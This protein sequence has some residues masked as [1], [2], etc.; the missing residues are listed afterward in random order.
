MATIVLQYAGAAVGTFLGGPLGGIIGR[1]VG[2]VVGNVVDQNLFGQSTSREG[3]RLNG[4]QVMSSEEGASIPVVFGRMRIG[5]QVIWASSIEE[6]A[7]TTTSSASGKGGPT[8]TTTE[9]SYFGSF[10]V[11]LCEG[12]IAGI[13]RVWADGQDIDIGQ[14]QTRL[15]TGS[16]TQNAD[17]L[18]TSAMTVAPAYR[19]LAYIVFERLPLASFG[20]RIP[21][22][23][24]EVLRA[25]TQL[26]RALQSV[27][28]IPGATEF[29]YDTTII[30]RN[31]GAGQTASE[32]AHVSAS[33]SDWSVSLNQLQAQCP[34]VS[35]ASLVVAWFGDDLRCGQCQ[36]RPGVDSPAKSTSPGT[37]SAGGISRAAAHQ[38]S[39][40]AGAPAFGGT[41]SDSSVVRAIQDMKARGFKVTFYPFILMDVPAGNAL[42]DPYGGAA[43][44]AYPWRGRMTA[45]KAPGV[46]GSPDKTAALTT[47]LASFVGT[48]TASNFATSGTAVTYSGPAEWS[49]RRMILHYAKLCAAAGGVDTFLIGSELVGL[50]TL[51]SSAGAYP[52]VA[53]LQTLAADVK[54]I[55]PSAKISYAADWSEYFGHHPTDGSNDVY[56]HLDPLWASSSI[57]F[58]GVDNYLPLADWRDGTAHL[59]FQAGT[60]TIYDQNYLQANIAGGEFYEWYYASQ[61]ARD[62][63][64]RSPITDGAYGKPWIYRAKDFKSWWLNPHYNRP[65]GVESLTATSWVAQSKPFRFTELGCPAVDKGL[66]QPN[67]FVDAKSSESA[68]PWYSNGTADDQ[69]QASYALAMQNYWGVSGS[70]NPV[71]TIYGGPMVSGADLSFWA[72]DARPYPAFPAKLDVWADG[73]N[74]QRGHWLNGRMASVEL[75]TLITE[76]ASRFG[77]E[78]VDVSGVD[79]RVDGFVIDRPMSARDALEGL[80]QAFAIDAVE[81]GGQLKFTAR[82]AVEVINVTPADL[83]ETAADQPILVTTRAQETDIPAA[84]K[85]TYAEAAVD[86]RSAAVSAR[87]PQTSSVREVTINLPAAI[88]QAEAQSRADMAL[89]ESW[90]ARESVKFALPPS[91]AEVEPG[92]VIALQGNL[93]RVKSL[94]EGTARKIEAQAFDSTLYAVVLTT[95]RDVTAPDPAVFGQSEVLLMDLAMVQA[96]QSPAPW[97]AAQA[98]PWPGALAVLKKTGAASFTFNT[99]LAKQATLGETLSVLP[100][101]LADRLDFTTTLDVKLHYGALQSV[102]DDELLNGANL[103]AVGTSATGF[104]IFQFRDATLIDTDSYRLS[105]LLRAQGGSGPEMLASRGIGESFVLL[106][107]AVQ[108][109]ETSTA[110]NFNSSWRIGP[111]QLDSGDPAYVSLDFAGQQKSLRPLSPTALQLSKSTTGLNFSWIRRGRVDSDSWDLAEIPLGEATELYQID[112]LGG[113]NLKRSLQQ[114]TP[115]YF[116]ANA[117]VTSDFGSW[118]ST[119]TVRVSQISAAFGQGAILERTFNV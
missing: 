1:A 79:A 58:I 53:A 98:T 90:A 47:E 82:R 39:L 72:W 116:Y 36:L 9:Y 56:F 28:L 45:S 31:T 19:G 48:A 94:T 100:A 117:D 52:F 17:S 42:P 2:G 95:P 91:F 14:Y 68:L 88:S 24:F 26:S 63:Q 81:S 34:N 78:D 43:Q 73:A 11:G 61:T 35:A 51:R 89:A 46:A 113:T 104:E 84:V 69:A 93:W 71:S 109:V 29:G 76:L 44:W 111:A 65:G 103:V 23:T 108:Q 57:D 87:K 60:R 96:S 7:S 80:L 32:N 105:G 3:P 33:L 38:V 13:A 86:Y 37:W 83:L 25:S 54:A 22:L 102:S 114:A 101:G 15:Y 107:G 64:V 6:V 30:K 8:N 74:Y 49:F 110:D 40:V 66:N 27:N 115:N 112:F 67:V 118:P 62:N 106:N 5:G 20:N 12:E 59:D 50:T 92:D 21:Q 119:L 41:P 75:S 16:E 18:I 4:L 55:L 99:S 97:V 77:F 70:H 10:A 85:L